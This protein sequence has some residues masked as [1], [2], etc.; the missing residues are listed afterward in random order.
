MEDGDFLLEQAVNDNID[1]ENMSLFNTEKVTLSQVD[2]RGK[3]C[4]V[5]RPI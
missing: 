5:Q 1:F 4:L 2:Q 3:D